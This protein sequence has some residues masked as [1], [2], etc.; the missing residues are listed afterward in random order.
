LQSLS[1]NDWTVI[2]TPIVRNPKIIFL[3]AIYHICLVKS[4]LVGI[5]GSQKRWRIYKEQHATQIKAD[6]MAARSHF[7]MFAWNDHDTNLSIKSEQ[8]C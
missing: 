1:K 8:P 3:A 4:L 5:D 6:M 7:L 2:K